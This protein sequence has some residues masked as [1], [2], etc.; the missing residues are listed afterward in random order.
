MKEQFQLLEDY[1]NEI[2]CC[3]ARDEVQKQKISQLQAEIESLIDY[4]CK[5]NSDFVQIASAK[6]LKESEG[7]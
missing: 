5:S 3:H 4:K 6:K 2:E 7:G 1:S